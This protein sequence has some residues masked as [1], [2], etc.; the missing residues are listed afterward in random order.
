MVQFIWFI[1]FNKKVI[2][3]QDRLHVYSLTDDRFEDKL[4]NLGMD[5][6]Q[7]C[8]HQSELNQS[9]KVFDSR[10]LANKAKRGYKGLSEFMMSLGFRNFVYRLYWIRYRSISK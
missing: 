10:C 1:W 3:V 6:R 4:E 5:W 8:P 7:L 2:T 9:V